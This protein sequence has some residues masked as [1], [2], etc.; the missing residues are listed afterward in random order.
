L[1][2]QAPF[3]PILCVL[4]ARAGSISALRQHRGPTGQ[5][6]A[7][8]PA[9]AASLSS[10]PLSSDLSPATNSPSSTVAR[11]CRASR[12]DALAQS[13][14]IY[15]ATILAPS[16][17]PLCASSPPPKDRASCD[18]GRENLNPFGRG[19]GMRRHHRLVLAGRLG[20]LAS[21]P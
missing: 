7:L 1:G 10:G 21:V 18:E 11:N 16:Y 4:C 2:L 15:V 3:W 8:T 19:W 9:R 6:L 17:S 20:K 12:C 5:P 14:P 13:M